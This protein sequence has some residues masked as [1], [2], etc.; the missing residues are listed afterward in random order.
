[1]E[2]KLIT[3]DDQRVEFT[4]VNAATE[5]KAIEL[6]KEKVNSGAFKYDTAE[7]IYQE[8]VIG[9]GGTVFVVRLSE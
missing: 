9:G 4:T 6:A 8:P 3:K 5:A 7:V 2:K 1:M